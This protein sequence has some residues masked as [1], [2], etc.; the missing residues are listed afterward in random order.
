MVWLGR[1]SGRLMTLCLGENAFEMCFAPGVD[2]L[3]WPQMLMI[4][5][6]G[7]MTLNQV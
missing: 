4:L 1:L 5:C 7:A 3:N 6:L 2:D